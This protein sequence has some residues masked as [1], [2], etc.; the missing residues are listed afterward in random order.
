MCIHYTNYGTEYCVEKNN[1]Y[2]GIEYA[3]CTYNKSAMMSLGQGRSSKDTT[4]QKDAH[5]LEQANVT[6]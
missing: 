2:T 5:Q 4:K 6:N 3:K 1:M